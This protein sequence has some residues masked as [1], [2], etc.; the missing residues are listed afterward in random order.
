MKK[1]SLLSFSAAIFTIAT[2]HAS[3]GGVR[4]KWLPDGHF[5]SKSNIPIT[6]YTYDLDPLIVIS[7]KVN[8]KGLVVMGG[9]F[10]KPFTNSN[11]LLSIKYPNAQGEWVTGWCKTLYSYNQYKMF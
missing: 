2:I 1:K 3:Y 4:A 10:N 11:I 9:Q 6:T 7:Q 8:E 5:V